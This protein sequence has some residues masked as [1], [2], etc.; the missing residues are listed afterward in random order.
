M[1]DTLTH[2]EIRE[3]VAELDALCRSEY[4]K[5]QRYGLLE[6]LADPDRELAAAR[7]QRLTGIL[8][9]RRFAK[10]QPVD[11]TPSD[12]NAN[13][14]WGWVRE[15]LDDRELQ[16]SQEFWV[17]DQMRQ[18]LPTL[19]GCP[20][21]WESFLW[22]ADH[23]RGVYKVLTLWIQDKWKGRESRSI[24]EYLAQE[25]TPRFDALLDVADFVG[26][27]ALSTALIPIVPFAPV[28]VPLTIIGAKYG[29]RKITEAPEEGDVED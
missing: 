18:Q 9:K 24:K 5:D 29:Y 27:A 20:A 13:R 1:A 26:Q 21:T 8:L 2:H 4:G 22:E 25:E 3:A 23:E 16:R 12:T 14:R 6:L 7:L 11:G 15:Q 28:V 19:V 10:A 17:L